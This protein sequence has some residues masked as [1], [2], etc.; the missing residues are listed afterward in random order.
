LLVAQDRLHGLGL[1]EVILKGVSA[2]ETHVSVLMALRRMVHAGSS[3]DIWEADVRQKE[4]AE[5]SKAL[6]D[7]EKCL[8]Q[9]WAEELWHRARECGVARFLPAVDAALP[10]KVTIGAVVGQLRLEG[11]LGRGGFGTVCLAH[12]TE[13]CDAEAVKL[14]PKRQHGSLDKVLS[15]AA[16]VEAMRQLRHKNV[17]ELLGV[18]HSKRHVMVRMQYAGPATLLKILGRSDHHRLPLA[19]ARG[20]YAQLVDGI[21]YCH[22]RGVA[23]CDLK[24]ENLGLSAEGEHLKVLDFGSAAKVDAVVGAPR[25]TMPFMAPEVILACHGR[26]YAPAPSDVW[27]MGV[28]LLEMVAGVGSVNQLLGWAANVEACEKTGAELLALLDRGAGAVRNLIH[29]YCG[30]PSAELADLLDATFLVDSSGRASAASLAKNPW[31][32]RPDRAKSDGGVSNVPLRPAGPWPSSRFLQ[33]GAEVGQP[34]ARSA[35]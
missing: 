25:G 16:E 15:V 13:T 22:S 6:K 35:L 30:P 23:H 9:Q 10:A 20:L 32:A 28:V 12:N 21:A 24:P 4:R 31:V 2:S 34:G 5:S 8:R 3:W 14:F 11:I 7:Q 29:K 17:V 27:A 26:G 33:R 18:L 19:R 1:D